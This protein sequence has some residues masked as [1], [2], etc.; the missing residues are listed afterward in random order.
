MRTANRNSDS[1]LAGSCDHQQLETCHQI[2]FVLMRAVP[3]RTPHFLNSVESVFML[4]SVL[5][6]D[7]LL[8]QGPCLESLMSSAIV[9][10]E[11]VPFLSDLPLGMPCLH[12]V[13]VLPAL[14]RCLKNSLHMLY[15]HTLKN[16]VVARGGPWRPSSTTM[17]YSSQG[18]V[19]DTA[20]KNSDSQQDPVIWQKHATRLTLSWWVLFTWG[21]LTSEILWGL[22]WN[23]LC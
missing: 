20:S 8:V 12:F 2:S 10:E 19:P 6:E 15:T 9:I 5:G 3:L 18:R 16:M 4:V 13:L 1:Q 11:L 22:S 17:T 21:C 7:W 14:L 23:C